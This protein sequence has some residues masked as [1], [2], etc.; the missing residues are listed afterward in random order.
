MMKILVDLT[1]F[2]NV[3]VLSDVQII[4]S[5]Y[6]ANLVLSCGSIAIIESR[7]LQHAGKIVKWQFPKK[8]CGFVTFSEKEYNNSVSK[9]NEIKSNLLRATIYNINQNKNLWYV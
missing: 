8:T 7:F 1:F 3:C 5:Y 9:K 2:P 4:A 6:M